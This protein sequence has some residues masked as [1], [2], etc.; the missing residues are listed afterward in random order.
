MPE[1]ADVSI[2][3]L[4]PERFAALQAL[5]GKDPAPGLVSIE[6]FSNVWYIR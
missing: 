6:F 2:K 5:A 1:P 3:P 4:T